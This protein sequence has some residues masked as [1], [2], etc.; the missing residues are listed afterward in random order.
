MG[1]VW[2]FFSQDA[3]KAMDRVLEPYV[4]FC[5]S[6]RV[7]L[8]LSAMTLIALVWFL[9][10]KTL[11]LLTI[12]LLVLALLYGVGTVLWQRFVRPS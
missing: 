10:S 4:R 2:D 6:H 12:G 9:V 11:A 5:L 1:R 3:N 8:W 7:L